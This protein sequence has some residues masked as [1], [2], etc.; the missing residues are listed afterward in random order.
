MSGIKLGRSFY[1]THVLFVD[2]V[3]LVFY[4]SRWDVNKIKEILSL[5]NKAFFF[6]NKHAKS[7][8][9]I[10]G[11]EEEKVGRNILYEFPFHNVN[12]HTYFLYL[13]LLLK[14]SDYRKIIGRPSL[15]R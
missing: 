6:G 8:M 12:F 2:D 9:A 1:L 13:G 7:S 14:P 10:N 4:G 3:L 5:Y 15:V 11:V